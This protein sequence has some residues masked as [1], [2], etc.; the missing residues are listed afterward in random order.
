[1][2]LLGTTH[3]VQKKWKQEAYRESLPLLAYKLSEVLKCGDDLL[4][5]YN[6]YLY[7]FAM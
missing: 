4:H 3:F 5:I 6:R 1:M 2:H 7:V